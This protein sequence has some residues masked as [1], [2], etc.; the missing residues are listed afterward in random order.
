ME[1]ILVAE[2]KL[3]SSHVL[4]KL[5]KY[6]DIEIA[7]NRQEF[8]N[9][10]K[11]AT[12]ILG[13]VQ[14]K[15]DKQTIDAAPRLAIIA[16]ASA[17]VNHIDQE[18]AKSKGIIVLNAPGCNARA[19]AEHTL[20]LIISLIRRIPFAF[21][22][23]RRGNWNPLGFEGYE[24]ENKTL[25]LVGFGKVPKTL[26]KIV[27]GL[28]I[29]AVA[30]DPYLT[31]KD[32]RNFDVGPVTLRELICCS[33]IISLH[34]PLTVETRGFI[35]QERIEQMRDGVYIVNTSRGEIIDEEALLDYLRK[36]KIAGYACDVLVGEPPTNSAILTALK[37]NSVPNVIVTPHIAHA[38]KEAFDNCGSVIANQVKRVLD[39]KTNKKARL[40]ED[41][42]SPL[43]M[44]STNHCF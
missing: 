2:P 9:K 16:T 4:K 1:K 31:K 39:E 34:T 14:N 28:G 37:E 11:N 15:L 21:D 27:K 29:N 43:M 6:G 3:Y 41:S 38:T 17:G 13:W 8:L 24:M 5:S 36:G 25:G 22:D 19:V 20:G 40:L 26:A 10:I 33:D 35:S 44:G 30:Y 18:Y 23:V 32:I 42:I 12:I 7:E